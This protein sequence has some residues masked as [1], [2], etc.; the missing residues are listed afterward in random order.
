MRNIV[1][2]IRTALEPIVF[3]IKRIETNAADSDD[4]LAWLAEEGLI[5]PAMA[6]DNVIYTDKDGAVFVL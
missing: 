2:I 1:D 4:V 5:E 6:D 3:M